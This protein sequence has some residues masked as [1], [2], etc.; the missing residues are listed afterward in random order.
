MKTLTPAQIFRG[1]GAINPA[2]PSPPVQ[3]LVRQPPQ[4]PTSRRRRATVPVQTQN[5]PAPQ[6]QPR[7]LTGEGNRIGLQ[8]LDHFTIDNSFLWLKYHAKAYTAEQF[9]I[10]RKSTGYRPHY[11]TV[12]DPQSQPIPANNGMLYQVKMLPGTII[13]GLCYWDGGTL[14]EALQV[15]EAK[16]RKL[17]SEPIDAAQWFK[18]SQNFNNG[19]LYL[20]E[21]F[22][23]EGD[24]LM[25]VELYNGADTVSSFPTQLVILTCEPVQVKEPQ[26]QEP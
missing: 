19:V 10:L 14:P 12:P 23:V 22:I 11:Y 13:W 21:L 18:N 17:F 9:D 16:G 1:L 2:C 3:A 15:R 7:Y 6:E 26:C 4:A 8:V 24:G 20:E 5:K 25:V